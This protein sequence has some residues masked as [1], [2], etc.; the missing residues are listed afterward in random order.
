MNYRDTIFCPN[1]NCKDFGKIKSKNLRIK[2]YQGKSQRIA[3]MECTTCKTAFSER[4]GTI[5]FGIKKSDEIFN[6]VMKML[7]IRASIKDIVRVTG[8][9]EETIGRWTKKAAH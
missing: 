6:L 4:K 2:Q 1:E 5:Y 9:S 3:L 7:M 8:V